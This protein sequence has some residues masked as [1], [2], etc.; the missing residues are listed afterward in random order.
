M[1]AITVRRSVVGKMSAV[2]FVIVIAA[3]VL[4]FVHPVFYPVAWLS[5]LGGALFAVVLW[6]RHLRSSHPTVSHLAPDREEG[7]PI[8]PR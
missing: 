8:H 4:G 5:L 1:G 6:T 2:A 3:F 7:K